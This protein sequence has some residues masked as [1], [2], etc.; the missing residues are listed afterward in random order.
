MISIYR[1]HSL[2]T[3]RAEPTPRQILVLSEDKLKRK[4][5]C[6]TPYCTVKAWAMPTLWLY[7]FMIFQRGGGPD[8]PWI[9]PWKACFLEKYQSHFH[10]ETRNFNGGFKPFSFNNVSVFLRI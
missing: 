10:D 6:N 4:V 3:N 8:P 1:V 2:E 9:R 7:I 5:I